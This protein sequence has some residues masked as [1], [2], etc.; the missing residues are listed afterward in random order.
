[1]VVPVFG[2]IATLPEVLNIY[3]N[4]GLEE[5]RDPVI[6]QILREAQEPLVIDC[7]VNVGI[8]VRW[9]LYLN[10]KAQVI[11]VDMLQEA[12]DFTRQAL[13]ASPPSYDAARFRGLPGTLYS[14]NGVEFEVAFDNP[15]DGD[16]SLLTASA[17]KLQKRKVKTLTLDH[18]F[19]DEDNTEVTLMKIDLEFPR[20]GC[21]QG[22]IT[23][24]WIV[25]SN[26]ELNAILGIQSARAARE[27]VRH[28]TMAGNIKGLWGKI[29][30]FLQHIR[31]AN[32]LSFRIQIQP[33]PNCDPNIYTTVNDQWLLSFTQ[34]LLDSWVGAIE[35]T[36]LS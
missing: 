33:P 5:L 10:P 26:L 20:R 23:I 31:T 22:I 19:A 21:E 30:G 36:K 18:L 15:L 34:D 1:M 11:G 25:E 7:G 9:W 35:K 4:F 29:Q 32:H 24:Q 13:Y 2:R 3:D 28:R 14:K 27:I 12:L 16:N 6:E 17:G 8:T